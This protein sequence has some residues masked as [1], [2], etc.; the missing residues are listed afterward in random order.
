MKFTLIINVL[1]IKQMPKLLIHRKIATLVIKY[2]HPSELHDFFWTHGLPHDMKFRYGNVRYDSCIKI[3]TD[4]NA[5]K[6]VDTSKYEQFMNFF[7]N[8]ILTG[9]N[10]EWCNHVDQVFDIV[11]IPSTIN[12]PLHQITH[13]YINSPNGAM[14]MIHFNSLHQFINLKNLKIAFCCVLDLIPLEK[15]EKLRKCDLSYCFLK[16]AFPLSLNVSGL[17]TFGVPNCPAEHD[18][19]LNNNKIKKLIM[20]IHIYFCLRDT[21]LHHNMSQYNRYDFD[22]RKTQVGNLRS[23]VLND[24]NFI[25][26]CCPKVKHLVIERSNVCIE[27]Q[28][29]SLRKLTIIHGIDN[30]DIKFISELKYLHTL[31]VFMNY[32][33]SGL[34]KISECRRLRR[35]TIGCYWGSDNTL[36]QV[37][38]DIVH[39][40]I[41]LHSLGLCNMKC[42]I[43][44]EKFVNMIH[45]K[46]LR[47]VNFSGERVMDFSGMSLNSLDIR[48]CS[49]V[50]VIIIPACIL[51][52][53]ISG[54]NN[55]KRVE[56]EKGKNA[57]Q[58]IGCPKMRFVNS[59]VK[60]SFIRRFMNAFEEIL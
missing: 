23:L 32:K 53:N 36:N 51:N 54:C 44:G 16:H 49:D 59:L 8:I 9:I 37:V 7:P 27:S 25:V 18:V 56:C 57:F 17:K 55:L 30:F 31:A 41:F 10:I 50:R 21:I 52:V 46:E 1:I 24:N 38:M 14:V 40:C 29:P 58:I 28:F 15:C 22:L 48:Y 47:I 60:P 42:K 5:T 12:V 35:L 11:D 2:L 34:E 19:L 6:I 45:L 43:D 4:K 33:L 39:K 3:R 26:P 13:M 20:P